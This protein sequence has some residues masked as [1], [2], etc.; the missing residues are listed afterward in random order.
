M[1]NL[2]IEEKTPLLILPSLAMKIGLNEAV[3]LQQ[4]HYWLTQSP[5]FAKGRRWVYNTYDEW[6]RQMPFWSYSTI[7]RIV[8]TLE[9]RGLLISDKFNYSKMD[10]TKWY[11]IDYDKVA[12][13]EEEPSDA[14]NGLL[15]DQAEEISRS[16]RTIFD[17]TVDKAI[18]EITTEIT[19][20]KKDIIP[21]VEIIDYLN[22]KI[23]GTF[24]TTTKKTMKFIR[25]R[26]REGHTLEDFKKVIDLKADEW[27]KDAAW[28]KYLRPETLFGPKFESYLN[29]KPRRKRVREE[30]LDLRD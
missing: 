7:K 1:S 22:L 5:H 3:L 18:P 21:F 26:Y 14:Q 30:D 25:A 13:L 23:N 27:L 15:P 4:V 2:V 24:K 11:T 16:E 20:E 6:N 10:Q 28:S 12:M 19:T 8:N 29:Q 17:A 9:K